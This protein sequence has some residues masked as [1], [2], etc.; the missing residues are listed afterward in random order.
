MYTSIILSFVALLTAGWF[1]QES[2]VQCRQQD[3]IQ[4]QDVFFAEPVRAQPI[5]VLE[6]PTF[7]EWIEI[8]ALVT[9]YTPHDG[10]DSAHWSTKDTVTAT[11]KDWRVHPY[12]IAADPRILPYG[13]LVRV[14]GY[15]SGAIFAVDDTG[16]AM[17]GSWKKGIVQVDLRYQTSYSAR[18]QGRSPGT[19][20]VNISSLPTT[21]RDALLAYKDKAPWIR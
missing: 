12:G 11:N 10:T 3:R 19:V 13:T 7:P 16:G 14:P 15:R 21:Q 8:P 17:R 6:R 20:L 1:W 5:V 2:R 18:K 4:Y 9:G